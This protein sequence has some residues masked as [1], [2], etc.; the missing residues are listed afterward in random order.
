MGVYL[1]QTQVA[2]H[3]V[4]DLF[5]KATTFYSKLKMKFSTILNPCSDKMDSG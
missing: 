3:Y 4:E 1:R 5:D 2:T